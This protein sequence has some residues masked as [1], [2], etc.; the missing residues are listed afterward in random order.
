MQVK[1]SNCGSTQLLNEENICSYC[2]FPVSE[3]DKINSFYL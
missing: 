3:L 1:C 2:H